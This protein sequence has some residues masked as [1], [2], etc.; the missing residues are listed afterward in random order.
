M[1]TVMLLNHKPM[2]LAGSG[3]STRSI[4]SE[5]A[6]SRAAVQSQHAASESARVKAS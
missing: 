1:K 3:F 4:D 2:S 6:Y 5:S